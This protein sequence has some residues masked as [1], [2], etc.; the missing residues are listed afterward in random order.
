MNS[1]FRR[2]ALAAACTIGAGLAFA[3]GGGD[4]VVF[5]WS[6]YEDPLLHPKEEE[7]RSPVP[8]PVATPTNTPE[9]ST[10]STAHARTTSVLHSPHR[11][12][13]RPQPRTCPEV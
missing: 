2:L 13:Q 8:T 11:G 6:G 1:T 4:L 10:T 3:K 5:D 7:P 12:A 9:S